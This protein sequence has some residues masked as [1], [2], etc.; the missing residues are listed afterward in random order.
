MKIPNLKENE[1]VL[2]QCEG[3]TGILLDSSDN[4]LDDENSFFEVF[5]SIVMSE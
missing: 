1:F 3:K 2:L 5:S 4:I